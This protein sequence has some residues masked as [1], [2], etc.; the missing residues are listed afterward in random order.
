MSQKCDFC[1]EDAICGILIGR[2]TMYACATHLAVYGT[3]GIVKEC[4]KTPT[5]T[6][7]C[8]YCGKEKPVDE[9][10]WYT[11]KRGVRR[12]RK[13]CKLCNLAERK[14]QRLRKK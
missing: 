5:T 8:M 4:N 7:V 9:F 1:K 10:Y 12:M 6:A 11:D 14:K 3:R 2:D 13:E